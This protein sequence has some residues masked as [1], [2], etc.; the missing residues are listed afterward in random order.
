[1]KGKILQARRRYGKIFLK[2]T[3]FYDLNNSPVRREH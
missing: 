3:Y 1:M 2:N